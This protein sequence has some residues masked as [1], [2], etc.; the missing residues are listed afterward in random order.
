[1][2]I[3]HKVTNATLKK[4][5]VRTLV[6]IV[7][8]ILSSAMM[9]AV[10]A[11]AF[12]C[13]DYMAQ[14]AISEQGN[15][16]GKIMDVA[17]EDADKIRDDSEVKASFTLTSLGY[18]QEQTTN[19]AKI[20][21]YVARP[22]AG[23]ME[24]MPINL[25]QG[26][27]PEDESEVLIPRHLSYNGGVNYHLG[28][29]LTLQLGDRW[30]GEERLTQSNPYDPDLSSE[31]E[32][33][34]PRT[35]V[36]FHVVG[37]Y[38]RPEFERRTAPG[39]TVL[40]GPGEG[41]FGVSEDIYVRIKHPRGINTFLQEC[42]AYGETYDAVNYRL[43]TALGVSRYS[44][45]Y[46][47][48]YG[49][50][51]ILMVL[52]LLG[53]ISLI[54]NAFSISVSDRTKQFG[55]LSSVGATKKQIRR[56]VRYESMML[57][58]I[59]I[60]LGMLGGI[61][62]ISITLR[63]T[64]GLF[65]SFSRTNLSPRLVVP[66]PA[67]LLSF[68]IALITVRISAWIP[69]RR[70]ASVS[71]IEAIRQSQDVEVPV[72]K[73][74]RKHRIARLFGLPGL[75]AAKY[76][77]RDKKKYRVT[78]LSL[79]MSIVLFISS[80]SFGLYLK[81]SVGEVYQTTEADVVYEYDP[82]SMTREEWEQAYPVLLQ[83]SGILQSAEA[84]AS[85]L[86]AI[87]PNEDLSEKYQE[88]PVTSTGEN[89]DHPEESTMSLGIY[90]VD[91]NVYQEYLREQHLTDLQTDADGIPLGILYDRYEMWSQD[92]NRFVNGSVLR[93]GAV[94]D[95]SAY[96]LRA[97]RLKEEKREEFLQLPPE[98]AEQLIAELD[99]AWYEFLEFSVGA[100]ADTRCFGIFNL[101]HGEP[102]RLIY[103]ESARD[104][105][106]PE[107]TEDNAYLF[108]TDLSGKTYEEMCN[109]LL[110]QEMPMDYLNDLGDTI[111]SDRSTITLIDVFSYGFI[112]LISLISAANV[113]HTITTNVGLRRR[114]F[115]MLRAVGMGK[116]QFHRM[117]CFE[118]LIYGVKALLYGL[119]ISAVVTFLIFVVIGRGLEIEFFLPGGA[120]A[121][122]VCSVFL[123]VFAT[124]YYSVWRVN[125]VNT[126]DALKEENL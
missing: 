36:T 92:E 50:V 46:T 27:L 10:I 113:F 114:E 74:P 82:N 52:I 15:W 122:A 35:E 60:P 48:L 87:L 28:D 91:E 120:I 111:R 103:P 75:L 71:A 3:F 23:F 55:L 6:T 116:R 45:F 97:Y 95:E 93:E 72:R 20:F 106:F 115:A 79:T 49:L 2:N 96:P 110:A 29:T 13:Q 99:P 42:S 119:P 62:G 85:Y 9:T 8:I 44:T 12:S 112:V 7:G 32:K 83:A 86:E 26:R 40:T 121:I 16:H 94:S 84:S 123:V 19:P 17:E 69:S 64:S 101:E 126:A 102:L 68:L 89:T 31:E 98:E 53:S 54:Y 73:R 38:A 21:L 37:F 81:K 14:I 24:N 109:L 41:L 78:V 11:L 18:A 118:S 51:T 58:V 63:A 80:A 25:V 5:K 67:L 107:G 43:M 4:N 30:A 61:L 1:M 66:L 70:A 90:F 105:L 56:M 104:K 77:E 117:L 47:V 125:Q 22:D 76:F 57:S 100:V 39:Y 59:G 108:R 88:I 124:M 65:R 34:I 33:F